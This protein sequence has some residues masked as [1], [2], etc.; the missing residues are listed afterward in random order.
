M[1]PETTACFLAAVLFHAL[2]LFGFRL[3]TPARPLAVS[4]EPPSEDVS[5][6]EAAPA[7]ASTLEAPAAPVPP[8]PTPETPKASPDLPT[9]P[10]E[11]TPNPD[12]IPPP[13][14]TPVPQHPHPSP[15]TQQ[16][17]HSKPY[18]L[19]SAPTASANLTGAPSHATAVGG[20]GSQVH[21]LS[22]PK[23]DYPEQARI[24]HQEGVVLLDVIVGAN[25]RP[26][27]VTLRRTSGFPLLDSA[28]IQAVRRWTFDPA[29]AAGLP[30][31]STVEIPLRFSLSK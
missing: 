12:A 10:P 25:G 29:R 30:V 28:A 5:L 8:Q 16:Q 22:N 18:P 6:V 20:L 11:P 1:K 27:S 14:S 24:Q 2:L 9:P 13:E 19:H 15:R 3:E 21:Y 23:P 26:T 17:K 4:D 7:A 31:P